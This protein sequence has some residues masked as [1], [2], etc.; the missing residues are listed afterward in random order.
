[1]I[2]IVVRKLEIFVVCSSSMTSLSDLE[3]N[4]IFLI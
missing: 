2:L 3:I 1:M 4:V